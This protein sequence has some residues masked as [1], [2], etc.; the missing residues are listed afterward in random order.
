M[1][2]QPTLT[3]PVPTQQQTGMGSVLQ[4]SQWQPGPT[5]LSIY[6][7]P[8]SGITGITRPGQRGEGG[9]AGIW[10]V[11]FGFDLGERC[12]FPYLT[13]GESSSGE[14]RAVTHSSYL[15]PSTARRQ[16][17]RTGPFAGA[18]CQKTHSPAP[19]G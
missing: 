2:T 3:Q 14:R 15:S 4:G 8:S 13:L 7:G 1:P 11:L 16:Q 17:R 18:L 6:S 9:T 19:C 10:Q 5:A 12:H